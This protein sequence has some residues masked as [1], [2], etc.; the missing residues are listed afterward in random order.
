[1]NWPEVVDSAVK[2][3]LGALIGGVVA[4]YQAAALFRRERKKALCDRRRELLEEFV[5]KFDAFG[6]TVADYHASFWN[7]HEERAKGKLTEEMKTK[8]LKIDSQMTRAFKQ[9]HAVESRLL[10]I[11]EDDLYDAL[12]DYIAD[13]QTLY[14]KT[15]LESTT[16]TEDDLSAFKERLRDKRRALL[17]AV[18]ERYEAIAL[19]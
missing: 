4:T 14:E 13:T 5:E 1:M 8:H 2:I 18:G 12:R 19:T 3:G 17:R 7:L 11:R 15:E 6:A 16:L 9:L 10:L